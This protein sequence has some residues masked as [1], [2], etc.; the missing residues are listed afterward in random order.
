MN[1][2]DM[3][4]LPLG[5]RKDTQQQLSLKALRNRLPEDKFLVRDERIDDK[6]VD[7]TLEAKI[8]VRTPKKDGGEELMHGFTNCRAQGQLKSIDNPE[9]NHDGSVSYSIDSTNLNYLL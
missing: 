8:Q 5:D 1:P 4:P 2:T 9:P 3:G 6:G 7:V